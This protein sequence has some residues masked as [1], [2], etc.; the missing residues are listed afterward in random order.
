MTGGYIERMRSP[1]GVTASFTLLLAACVIAPTPEDEL[2]A[3]DD[4]VRQWVAAIV[5]DSEA[6]RGY[7]LLHPEMRDAIPLDRYLEAIGGFQDATL[8]WHVLPGTD[9]A[10]S[11]DGVHFAVEVRVEGGSTALPP[12]LIGV[13]VMEQLIDEFGIHTGI[14]VG[15]K[16]DDAGLGIWWPDP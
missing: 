8:E 1:H 6:E 16:S 13:H 3:A 14:G 11:D 15:V 5:V 12:N 7:Q 10:P 4:I 9:R 2:A